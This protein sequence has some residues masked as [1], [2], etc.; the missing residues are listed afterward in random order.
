[1]YITAIINLLACLFAIFWY[2]TNGKYAVVRL[3]QPIFHISSAS[4]G[5]IASVGTLLL[6]PDNNTSSMCS[7]S[8]LITGI[9][10]M[11]MYGSIFAKTHRIDALM[12]NKRLKKVK[13]SQTD[14]FTR[15]M[16]FVII[17]VVSIVALLIIAPVV[18]T[19]KEFNKDGAFQYTV[20]CSAG[21]NTD[22]WVMVL[23]IVQF[24]LLGY[25]CYLAYRIRNV[26][27]AMNEA[28]FIGI[29]LYTSFL[30]GIVAIFV[31]LQSMDNPELVYMLGPAVIN[32]CCLVS[33]L[34]TLLPKVISLTDEMKAMTAEQAM[35]LDEN[36]GTS[37][38]GSNS[39]SAFSQEPSTPEEFFA[40]IDEGAI[41]NAVGAAQKEQL[42]AWKAKC[43]LIVS[44]CS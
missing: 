44:L 3:T 26:K 41:R 43:E 32:I 30:I 12:N 8:L 39:T 18:P 4:G 25:G 14:I 28:F 31:V 10:L 34:S 1:M 22:M 36:N 35:K 20:T 21:E 6:L 24:G 5:V 11:G 38:S 16:V 27:G 23:C 13:V 17:E 40:S 19:V 37:T 15:I 2:Q 33:V 9:G 42:A 29:S 7:I